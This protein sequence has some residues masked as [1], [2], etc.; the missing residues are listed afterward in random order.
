[1]PRRE[2][3]HQRR[4]RWGWGPGATGKTSTARAVRS[5]FHPVE[6]AVRRK[7]DGPSEGALY[8]DGGGSHDMM[9]ISLFVALVL[10][11][12][13][14]T[15]PLEAQRFDL[16][17]RTDFFLGFSGDEA[18]LQ[19]AMEACET[20]LAEHPKHAEALVWHGAGLL[21]RAGRSFQA[22]DAQQGMH[23]FQSGLSQMTEA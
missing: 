3:R 6:V 13:G 2:P 7:S 17:V 16:V 22:G 11:V 1:M 9:I 4:T 23:L 5:A 15:V 12:F 14:S 10:T 18:R 20:V 21:F 8:R 19:K